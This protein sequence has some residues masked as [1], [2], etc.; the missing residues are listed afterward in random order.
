MKRQIF[1]TVIALLPLVSCFAKTPANSDQEEAIH[2]TYPTQGFYGGIRVTPQLSWM[3]NKTDIDNSS[4]KTESRFGVALGLAGGYCFTDHI[5]AEVNAVYSMEGKKYKI[6]GKEYTQKVDYIKIPL[7]FV[8]TT[9]PSTFMFLG[10]I[11]PQ[12]N[13]LSSAKISPAIVNSTTI[14]DNKKQFENAVFGAA[15]SAGVRY[16]IMDNLWLD[17]SIRYDLSFTNV[18]NKNY[19]HY[20]AGR[21]DTHNMT[22]GLE[23]GFNYL[24]K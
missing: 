1:T 22:T 13:I 20:P 24:F 16:A 11:G 19:E 14:S 2:S 17:A 7:L 23:I 10:K 12:L 18:E 9:R 6:S 3:L 5:G 15:A 8:Y 4:Y 21:S